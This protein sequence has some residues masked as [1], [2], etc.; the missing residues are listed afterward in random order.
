[1]TNIADTSMNESEQKIAFQGEVCLGHWAAR[2][3]TSKGV[4]DASVTFY[5]ADS[6][7]LVCALQGQETRGRSLKATGKRY[8]MV[9]VELDDDEMPVIQEPKKTAT[10]TP[11]KRRRTLSQEAFLTLHDKSQNF[12]QWVGRMTGTGM[13]AT[14]TEADEY[15]KDICGIDSKS[16]LDSNERAAQ[17]FNG[18]MGAFRRWV[19]G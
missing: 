7:D 16:E 13:T 1:M 6:E 3:E 4:T 9:L 10:E 15:I 18:M 14:L 17:K 12:R 19:N 5:S 8:F 2:R 11:A